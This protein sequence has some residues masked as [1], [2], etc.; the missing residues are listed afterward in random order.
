MDDDQAHDE[1][2]QV[3][4]RLRPDRSFQKTLWFVSGV[5]FLLLLLT[6]NLSRKARHVDPDEAFDAKSLSGNL[7]R[8]LC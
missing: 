8:R 4:T 3:G 5:M 2:S 6:F 7:S 1:A